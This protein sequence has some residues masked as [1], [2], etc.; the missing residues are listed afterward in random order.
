MNLYTGATLVSAL[1][2]TSPVRNQATLTAA[3]QASLAAGS[4]RVAVLVNGV[5]VMS[6]S[7]AC[8]SCGGTGVGTTRRA[9]RGVV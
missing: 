4:L 9:L 3:N 2:T 8:V 1:G 5:E 6:G 7:L